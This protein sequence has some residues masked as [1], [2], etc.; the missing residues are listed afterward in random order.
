MIEPQQ[1]KQWVTIQPDSIWTVQGCRSWPASNQKWV[2]FPCLLKKIETNLHENQ[3]DQNLE[4]R[5]DKR[6]IKKKQ[7]IL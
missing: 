3:I 4:A 1:N 7:V 2:D 6:H 5:P